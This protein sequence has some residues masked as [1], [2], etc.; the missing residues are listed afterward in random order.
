MSVQDAIEVKKNNR[1]STCFASGIHLEGDSAPCS[2]SFHSCAV[3][4]GAF[5]Y[6][7]SFLPSCSFHSSAIGRCVCWLGFL[8]G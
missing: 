7:Y 4:C 3:A 1:Q 2:S 5:G 6:Y 8:F